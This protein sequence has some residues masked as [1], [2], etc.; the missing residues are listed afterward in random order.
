MREIV[1]EI[2]NLN[3]VS[4]NKR[5]APGGR[6]KKFRLT[7]VYLQYKEDLKFLLKPQIPTHWKPL[8]NFFF[9]FM[10]STY[11][12]AT[13][14]DKP[15]L[16]VMK[17]VGIIKDDKFLLGMLLLKQPIKRTGQEE[18]DIILAGD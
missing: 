3:L 4:E 18:M 13:N 7:P 11:K 8:H 12:D 10:V 6:N 16:D 1:L 5:L 17:D 9:T 15:I 2:R 14:L